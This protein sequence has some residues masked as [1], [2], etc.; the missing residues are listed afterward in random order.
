MY[1]DKIK[2]N[3]RN[4]KLVQEFSNY[5]VRN[6][7]WM[8]LGSAQ[9]KKF[10]NDLFDY[11]MANKYYFYFDD[12]WVVS[13]SIYTSHGFHLLCFLI[14]TADKEDWDKLKAEFHEKITKGNINSVVVRAAYI[15]SMKKIYTLDQ[16][17]LYSILHSI[18]YGSYQDMIV[19]IFLNHNQITEPSFFD[20]LY[21]QGILSLIVSY[22]SKID[23]A[24]YLLSFLVTLFIERKISEKVLDTVLSDFKEIN[25]AYGGIG[26]LEKPVNELNEDEVKRIKTVLTKIEEVRDVCFDALVIL[27][28]E[29][30]KSS[31]LLKKYIWEDVMELAKRGFRD[32]YLGEVKKYFCEESFLTNEEK[33]ILLE[34][35][36]KKGEINE[37]YNKEMIQIFDSIDWSK[38]RD[39]FHEL[40]VIIQRQ[41]MELSG[42]LMR[43]FQLKYEKSDDD[44]IVN[45]SIKDKKA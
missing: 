20:E 23:G 18:F 40:I 19:D 17:Y 42:Q 9:F 7:S 38:N 15:F 43:R 37:L 41:N 44:C 45:P 36:L 4:L 35:V 27:L 10:W 16:E 39:N 30:M 24:A 34:S 26:D 2:V 31:S 8:C 14:K 13:N 11:S 21:S 32:T 25:I 5:L 29:M 3:S 1:F 33:I 22:Q 28:L 12:S 6:L